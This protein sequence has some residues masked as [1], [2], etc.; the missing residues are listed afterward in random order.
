MILNNLEPDREDSA[1][2]ERVRELEGRLNQQQ[3]FL[4]SFNFELLILNFETI[5]ATGFD[6]FDFNFEFGTVDYEFRNS[7]SNRFFLDLF[8]NFN[9]EF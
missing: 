4:G 8:F 9:F 1:Q 3:V 6:Y 5:S 2:G 7:I